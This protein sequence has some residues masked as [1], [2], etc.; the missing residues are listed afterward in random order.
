MILYRLLQDY[1]EA[2]FLPKCALVLS[3]IF[4]LAGSVCF[5]AIEDA[6]SMLVFGFLGLFMA[7]LM[8]LG[9]FIWV[10]INP[11]AMLKDGMLT[12][13]TRKGRKIRCFSLH[14]MDIIYAWVCYRGSNGMA[15]NYQRS[16]VLYPKGMILRKQTYEKNGECLQQL[17]AWARDRKKMVFIINKELEAKILAYYDEHPIEGQE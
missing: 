14:E 16:F 10:P 9:Y 17:S 15:Y 5:L 11:Y 4:H 2:I 8:A 3:C 1:E 6:V 12:V 7:L 13:C